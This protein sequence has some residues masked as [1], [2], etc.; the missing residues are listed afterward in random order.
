[1]QQHNREAAERQ[2]RIAA[3][4]GDAYDELL[5]KGIQYQ[6]KEDWRKAAKRSTARP[7]P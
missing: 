1:M 7:S 5:A 4:S 6:S 2:A 3:Q